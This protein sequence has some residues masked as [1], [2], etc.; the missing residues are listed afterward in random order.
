MIGVVHDLRESLIY[1][2]IRIMA[3]V[4]HRIDDSKRFQMPTLPQSNHIYSVGD[5]RSSP[6]SSAAAAA[7]PTVSKNP[8]IK[9]LADAIINDSS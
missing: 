4:H 5:N 3:V 9:A 6:S 1:R 7:V 8:K 2:D